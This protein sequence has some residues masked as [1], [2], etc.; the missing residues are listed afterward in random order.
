M[1]HQAGFRQVGLTDASGQ[2]MPVLLLY[3]TAAAEQPLAL[4]PYE[5]ALAPGALPAAGC[6]PL[7][8]VSHGSGGSP[9]V[10]RDLARRLA[11]EGMVVALP[12]H[13]GNNRNDNSQADTLGNFINRP[14]HI[15]RVIDYCLGEFAAC[16]RPAA[17]AVIGHSLGGYTA[18]A[19]AG[20]RPVTVPTPARPPQPIPVQADP[21]VRA[22][23]LLAPA[24]IWYALLPGALGAVDLPILLLLAERDELLPSAALRQLLAEGVA[25]PRLLDCRVI[26]GAGHFAFLSPFPAAMTRPGFAP[27]QDP[28]GFDRAAFQPRLEADVLAFLHQALPA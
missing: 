6:F 27:S 22:L 25:D 5:L 14:D 20:G 18:L 16:L 17:I 8:V 2:T 15:R 7:V 9:L 21:R 12:E 4:G 1:S 13:P 3:P 28:P 11:R 24:L 19:L 23:V 10:Y 26:S